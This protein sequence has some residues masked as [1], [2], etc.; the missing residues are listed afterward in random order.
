MKAYPAACN[1]QLKT[2]RKKTSPQVYP[3]KNPTTGLLPVLTIRSGIRPT[4][5]SHPMLC[6]GKERNNNAPAVPATNSGNKKTA[7]K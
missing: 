1:I 2:P 5:A 6:G 3:S 4:Q 7:K